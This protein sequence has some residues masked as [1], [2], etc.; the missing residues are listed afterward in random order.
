MT[1]CIYR[2]RIESMVVDMM[3]L[4]SDLVSVLVTY[5][6]SSTVD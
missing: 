4:E 5:I 3:V 1:P 2:R 6:M